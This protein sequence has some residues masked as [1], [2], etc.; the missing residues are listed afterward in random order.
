MKIL[1]QVGAIPYVETEGGLLVLLIT[2]RGR[3]RWTIPKGWPNPGM[4]DPQLAAQ[5]AFEEAG[6]TGKVSTRPV[7]SYLYT[8]HLHLFSWVKCS[9]E[10][11]LLRT[12]CQ[13]LNWPEK[14][15]RKSIWLEPREAAKKVKEPQLASV[16][17]EFGL[18]ATAFLDRR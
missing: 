17:R 3:G 14:P 12:N 2:T 9:V 16:L 5:E 1:K 18:S 11:Y 7:G 13:H 10:V 8:K 6:V 15:S 4:T